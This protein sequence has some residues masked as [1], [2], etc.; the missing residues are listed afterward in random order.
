MSGAAFGMRGTCSALSVFSSSMSFSSLITGI[1]LAVDGTIKLSFSCSN[2]L[3]SSSSNS[4]SSSY[5]AATGVANTLV[6]SC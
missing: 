6:M 4:L 1:R 5:P 3:L 2:K